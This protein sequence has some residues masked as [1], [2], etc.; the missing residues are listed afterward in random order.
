LKHPETKVVGPERSADRDAGCRKRQGSA[1]VE[2]LPAGIDDLVQFNLEF[3]DQRFSDDL[4][5]TWR[6]SRTRIRCPVRM[7][8]PS[9]PTS[10]RPTLQSRRKAKAGSLRFT[11]RRTIK[12]PRTSSA[13]R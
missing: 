11:G 2:E 9:Q 1:P 6:R 4:G 12:T 5:A 7:I 8:P 3:F 13:I 10:G